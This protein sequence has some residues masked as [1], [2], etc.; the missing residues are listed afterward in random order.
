M[1]GTKKVA[2]IF[3][4]VLCSSAFSVYAQSS[5][6]EVKP[7]AGKSNAPL[8]TVKVGV[9]K[10][11]ALTNAWVAKT[12]GFYEKNGLNVQLVEFKS[13]SEAIFAQ[14]GGDVDIILSIPGTAMSASEKGFGLMAIFQNESA[15]SAAPDSGTLLVLK[16]SNINSVK[17]LEGKK[18][19]TS[20]LHTQQ[21]VA[22]LSVIKK[23]GVD[24]SKI[25]VI[26]IPYPSHSD[27]LK[28]KQV[29]AVAPVDPFSTHILNSGNAKVLSYIYVESLP[30][31]P[32]GAWFVKKSWI[33]GHEDIIAGFNKSLQESIDYMLADPARARNLVAEYTGLDPKL[34][35][36]MPAIN[37]N[38]KV[39][40]SKWQ[41]VIKMM[42]DS[43]ELKKDHKADEY[44]SDQIKTY[45]K[46]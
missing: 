19:A 9:L 21:A 15:Q 32:L 45:I 40:Q 39:D 20:A 1:L 26:E 44:L 43:G 7:A 11:A 10:I 25:Q 23:A 4:L 6:T 13:G 2:A 30:E 41:G 12:Q 24:L 28:S 22:L 38:Y 37:W 46:K 27:V 34:V 5:S 8:K 36:A 42:K 29:D 18:I 17:D 3:A 33:K 31:Q 16:D 14:R 35:Q